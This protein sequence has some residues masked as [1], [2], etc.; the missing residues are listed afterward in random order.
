MNLI[1][2]A[3]R[4]RT[5]LVASLALMS[6]CG[7]GGDD[8]I[9][10]PASTTTNVTTTVIDGVLKNALVCLDK[11]VNGKCD[12][13]EV[14][15]RTDAAGAVTLAVPNGD[16]GKY[17]L[18][19][20]VGSD[21]LDD[22]V[23]VTVPYAMTAP[24]DQT[25][26]VSP[27]TTLVQQTVDTTG[28]T[29]AEAA[30]SLRDTTGITASLFED[31]TKAAAPSDGSTSAAL[32]GRLLVLAQQQQQTAVKGT[33]GTTAIDGATI[34]QADLDKAIQKQLLDLLP[35]L[36]TALGSPAVLA[37]T[38]AAERES[39][40]QGQAVSVAQSG[41]LT[42]ASVT[43][44]VGINNQAGV[45]QPAAAP[46]ATIQ[47]TDFSFSDAAN[48]YVRLLTSSLAQSTPDAGNM[49][50]YVDRRARSVGGNVARW[51][52]GGDPSRNA[53]LNWNGTA[54]AGCPINYENVSSVRDALGKNTYSYCDQRETGR[55]NR[56]TFDVSGKTMAEV[57]AQ[58]KAGGYS[59]VFIADPSVL[60]TATFP[61]GSAVF[62]HTNTPLTE[63]FAYYPGGAENPAGLS[64]LVS[65][66]SAAV[67]AGGDATAQPA[68]VA[69][70]SAETVGNG[71][72][73][74]TL[75]A[76][77]AAKAGTPCVFGP[78]SFVYGGVTYTSGPSNAWWGNS[79]VS[80]GKLGTAPV[81]SGPAP[82]FY[83][84]NTHL[85][86][87]FRGTGINPVTYYACQERFNNGSV[88]NCAAIGTGSYAIQ[89]LGDGRVM[90]F[91]GPPVQ[92][93][94]L[95]YNRVLVERGGHVYL[96]YQ[97]KALV[98]A[99]VRMNTTATT[100]LL[101]RLG[102]TAEDP[103]V[104][105]ALSAGSYQGTWDV[106]E[107]GQAI[108]AAIGT[109][110]FIN[111]NGFVSCFDRES[112]TSNACT[113]TITDPATGAFSFADSS[114]TASGT[115]NFHAGTVSGTYHDPSNVPVDGTFSG[116][117]R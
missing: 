63:A 37:A 75:E 86:I 26:V 93:A 7:G 61:A 41:G 71:V 84:G 52:S 113:V 48:Y 111:A 101:A 69:C 64:N 68:G 36:V 21:A 98:K 92:A 42:P 73:S 70:N 85:R 81:G 60:G 108:D 32:M 10:P 22:G 74:T 34:T 49:T 55:T 100:A 40:L 104:P 2:S 91:S 105:L 114:S 3:S 24:P 12:A 25:G 72:S 94:A 78:G 56:S 112:N 33:L 16:V 62:Y 45:A 51:G 59:N 17:P 8:G 54:W 28:A 87:A 117:R 115:F 77:I 11:N 18:L 97:S 27:L 15:G 83:T 9:A 5:A 106:R 46:S 47:L 50:R 23:A 96:G 99:S 6:A 66:Y 44:A 39:A 4:S 79:T 110:V 58:I 19:A 35:D 31:Y 103:S 82:G 107:V 116:G 102:I 53:D 80:L 76:M 20:L 88:R 13:D 43:V 30:Q 14:Q 38:T 109:T 95:N 90:T 29:S 65:Q 89:T 57:Y 1:H 67:S